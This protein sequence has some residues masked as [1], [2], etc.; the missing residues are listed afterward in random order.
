MPLF[1]IPI[2]VALHKAC[3]AAGV[4]GAVTAKHAA[5]AGA[6]H[7]VAVAHHAAQNPATTAE[8]FIASHAKTVLSRD[9]RDHVFEYLIKD[10]DLSESCKKYI[11]G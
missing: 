3:I 1:L 6:H 10:S 2:A 5:G 8:H 11:R 7:A 9:A 4:K